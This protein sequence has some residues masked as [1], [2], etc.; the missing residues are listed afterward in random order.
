MG[1]GERGFW[2]PTP[3]FPLKDFLRKW[4]AKLSFFTR[5]TAVIHFCL[6]LVLFFNPPYSSELGC[7]WIIGL[8]FTDRGQ[9][10]LY[11]RRLYIIQQM[12][13]FRATVAESFIESGEEQLRIILWIHPCQ[14]KGEC[15]KNPNSIELSRISG[16]SSAVGAKVWRAR[17]KIYK[18]ML[19]VSAHF[20]D[21]HWTGFKK[22]H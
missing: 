2:I 1:A 6:C 10:S 19:Y 5:F 14:K 8:Q 11:R 17:N 16:A 22:N 4:N 3:D 18:G 20:D 9:R 13:D 7:N 21:L 12:K 15:Q